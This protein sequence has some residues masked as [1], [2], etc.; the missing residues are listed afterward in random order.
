MPMSWQELN[1]PLPP[2]FLC[3]DCFL[4]ES[5]HPHKVKSIRQG[6]YERTQPSSIKQGNEEFKSN[7]VTG[8][9]LAF[10]VVK[11]MSAP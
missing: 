6:R 1:R 10:A 2:F 11:G 9:K 3:F 4:S 7:C 5:S 8:K